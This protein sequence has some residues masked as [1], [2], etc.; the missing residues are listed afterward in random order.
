MWEETSD[1]SQ[2]TTELTLLWVSL[3]LE[4]NPFDLVTFPFPQI[5]DLLEWLVS[6]SCLFESRPWGTT[7]QE[8]PETNWSYRLNMMESLTYLDM[9]FVISLGETNILKIAFHLEC[10]LNYGAL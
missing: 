10:L 4:H 2:K 5:Y 3:F 6:I 9:D 7:A 1:G 8:C